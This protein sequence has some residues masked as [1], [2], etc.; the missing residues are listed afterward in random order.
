MENYESSLWKDEAQN[1]SALAKKK[2]LVSYQ[3]A[4]KSQAWWHRISELG[5]PK[6]MPLS[7]KK[8]NGIHNQVF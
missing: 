4:G 1:S 2:V 8:K 7:K 3:N 6:P 5:K